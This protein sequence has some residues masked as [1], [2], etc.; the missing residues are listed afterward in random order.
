MRKFTE[1]YPEIPF[2][3]AVGRKRCSFFKFCPGVPTAPQH[4][5]PPLS[6]PPT[7]RSAPLAPPHQPPPAPVPTALP[8]LASTAAPAT[9]PATAT[10]DIGQHR[11]TLPR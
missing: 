5:D 9:A 8:V 10:E 1:I 4:A 6:L 2:V 7:R 3:I 11:G